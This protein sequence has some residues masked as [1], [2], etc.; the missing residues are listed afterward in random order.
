MSTHACTMLSLRRGFCNCAIADFRSPNRVLTPAEKDL[1]GAYKHRCRVVLGLLKRSRTWSHSAS[2]SA[3]AWRLHSG[4]V[5]PH[6]PSCAGLCWRQ[7]FR[8]LRTVNG[9]TV[10][11]VLDCAQGLS[12]GLKRDWRG[13][14]SDTHALNKCFEKSRPIFCSIFMPPKRRFWKELQKMKCARSM[15]FSA[16][17]STRFGL[18]T[19]E[20]SIEKH[21]FHHLSIRPKS[22]FGDH[23]LQCGDQTTAQF[24]N[25]LLN[26]EIVHT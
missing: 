12:R 19:I 1:D 11:R 20:K 24:Q 16:G 10:L 17:V 4:L 22:S 18:R 15:V 7:M 13:Q 14:Y 23:K 9:S 2:S 8:V 3:F 25:P 26:D 21:A 6:V 5:R